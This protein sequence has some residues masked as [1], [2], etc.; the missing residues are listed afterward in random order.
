VN[1]GD[2]DLNLLR[3]FDAVLREKRVTAAAARLGLTQPAVSN[4]LARLRRLFDDPLFMRT[5]RGMEPTAFAQALAAPVHEALGLI[6]SALAHRAGFEPGSSARSFRFHMSDIGEIFFLPPLV[7]RVRREAPNVRIEAQSV[8]LDE[9]P[10]ALA[11]GELDLAM[12]FL[13]ELPAPVRSRRLF[14][15][16]YVCMLRVDHPRIGR[17]L[18]RRQF[19]GESHALVSSMGSGHRVIEETLE[20]N[21]IARRIA[22]RVPHFTVLPMV[23]ERTD[24]L[25]TIPVRIAR[26][27]EKEGR[28]RSLRLPVAIPPAEIGLHWHERFERDPGNRWLRARMLELFAE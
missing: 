5:P 25:L 21:G 24:L 20:K 18:T 7:E 13:P 28:L 26:V 19:V 17:T 15:D 8:P 22:L 11:T 1:V 2:I 14:R 4:A 9:I 6:E 16:P 10:A 3:A 27:L 23:L 12:G